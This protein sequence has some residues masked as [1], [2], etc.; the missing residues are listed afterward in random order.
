MAPA[1]DALLAHFDKQS[2]VMR[3]ANSDVDIYTTTANTDTRYL[4]DSQLM[5]APTYYII[6]CCKIHTTQLL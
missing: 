4:S 2:L 3:N 1:H 5:A 6:Y